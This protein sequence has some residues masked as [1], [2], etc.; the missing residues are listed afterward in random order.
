MKIR[1][2][3]A[4]WVVVVLAIGGAVAQ[5]PNRIVVPFSDPS[6]PGTVR[7][8]LLSGSIRVTGYAGKE[9]VVE[10]SARDEEGDEDEDAKAPRAPRARRAPSIP[11]PPTPPVPPTPPPS[12]APRAPRALEERDRDE[13]SDS[14]ARGLRRIP[15]TAAGLSVGEEDNV[16]EIS[17]QSFNRTVDLD[18]HVPN[19]STLELATV[20]DGEVT[21]RSFEGELGIDNT[22]GDVRL[23]NVGGSIVVHALNGEV[24]ARLV[25]LDPK[26][27][28][29]FSSLNG[30][31][32]V[33]L[34]ADT[35]ADVWLKSDNGEIYTDFDLQVGARAE[36]RDEER[37]KP[38]KIKPGKHRDYGVDSAMYGTLNGGGPALRFETFNG[39]IYIRKAK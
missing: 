28:S 17:A 10:P 13:D 8:H 35:R 23:E 22:N 34:P 24:E 11:T 2:W 32:D 29:S 4:V 27:A 31:L 19:G 18:V 9:V 5:S 6:R 1:L 37:G 39:N 21:V 20:N 7:I 15:N 3:L 30:N 33:T 26:R 38:S 14:R 12:P 16:V 36:P 25:R